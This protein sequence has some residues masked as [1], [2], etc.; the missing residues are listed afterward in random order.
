MSAHPLYLPAH[1]TPQQAEAIL[2]RGQPLLIIAGPGSGKTEVISW[3]VAH[4]IKS[5]A[6]R[7]E[8]LLVTTFTNKAALEL[9]DR[10]QRKLPEINVEL[11]QVST[12]HSFCADLLRE[13][14]TQSRL[15]ANFRILDERGQF[16]FVYA[17]RKRLGLDE[18]VKGR[19]IDFFHSVVGLFNLATEEMVE[20][21]KFHDWCYQQQ[22]NCPEDETDLW[23][24]HAIISDA[25]QRYSDLLIE[26]R[27]ADFAFLQRFAVELV[28]TH[29]DI[30]QELRGR[31]QE[32]LVDEYQDTNAAQVHLLAAIVGKSGDGLAVVGDDDQSIYRFRG[33]T[34]KNILHF[35]EHFPNAHSI[36]LGHNF[37]SYESIVV[38]SL[39]VIIRNPARFNKE[40]LTTR[41]SGSETPLIYEHTADDEAKAVVEF[42]QYLRSFGKL[43]HWSDVAILR[44]RGLLRAR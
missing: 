28:E 11:M 29:S 14:A 9:K 4:L 6:A 13:Y 30:A 37:R 16:L 40:L 24:E 35:R 17:N 22:A 23:R 42:L 32:V 44:R 31:F 43:K 19:A 5:G 12:L 18:I 8:N 2:F 3:R 33:A 38:R 10:I 27:L 20:P 21:A 39:R 41:G 25:Y 7:P 34:V 26:N 15:P 36:L 1:L